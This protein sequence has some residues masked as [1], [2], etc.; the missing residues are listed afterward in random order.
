MLRVFE[1][2]YEKMY[3]DNNKKT[4]GKIVR[5]RPVRSR[6]VLKL[7]TQKPIEIFYWVNAGWR[8]TLIHF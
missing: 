4:Y 8:P 6:P 3:G 5:S 2:I 7:I 1:D